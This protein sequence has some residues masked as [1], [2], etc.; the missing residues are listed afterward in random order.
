MKKTSAI[1][2]RKQLGNTDKT[3]TGKI[4]FEH[5]GIGAQIQDISAYAN[6]I[7]ISFS[8][9]ENEK[10]DGYKTSFS[11]INIHTLQENVFLTVVFSL[12]MQIAIMYIMK[13]MKTQ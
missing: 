2:Y 5:T 1:L 10:G 12:H 9:Y 4:A 6:N 13:M 7:Y 11:S 3:D 8:S